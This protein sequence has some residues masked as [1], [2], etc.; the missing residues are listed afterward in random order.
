VTYTTLALGIA[1]A[2]PALA[3]GG[4]ARGRWLTAPLPASAGGAAAFVATFA[5]LALWSDLHFFFVHRLLHVPAIYARVHK[6]HHLSKNPG[7]WSGL[8]MHPVESALYLSKVLLPL[9][10]PHAHMLHFLFMLYN[11]TLMPIPGH[12][13]HEEALGNEYHVRGGARACCARCAQLT[14]PPPRA[15]APAPL[16][17]TPRSGSTTTR[18]RATTARPPSRSI[19]SL[20]RTGSSRRARRRP[21]E[22]ASA[23]AR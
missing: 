1:S 10:L 11:A 21:R 7:P 4:A 9:A 12:S 5:A 17:A 18:S 8:S 16:R 6:L 19:N 23:R 3:L 20:A 15:H 2:Y 14:L 13:G 22:E